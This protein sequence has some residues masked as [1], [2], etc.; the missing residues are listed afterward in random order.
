MNWEG[1]ITAMVTPLKN[2]GEEV[3]IDALKVYCDF[4]VE[5]NI[6]GVFVCGT[7]GEGPK[8]K[9][10]ERMKI[11]ETVVERLKG[12]IKTIIH[13]GTIITS[14][15]IKLSKHAWKIGADAVVVVLPYYY[16]YN[17]DLLYRYFMEIANVI[18]E[19]PL[20]IYNIPQCAINNLTPD[21]FKRLIEN[22]P[23]IVGI[24]N[25]N[26]DIHQDIEFIQ[27]ANG[28]CSLFIGDDGLIV[29]GLSMGA[30]GLVSGNASVFP[31]YFVDLYKTFKSGNLIAAREKQHFINKLR[32]VLAREH[33]IASFKKAL[34]FRGVNV[35]N[36]RKPDQD[37]SENE[38]NKLK[39]ALIK[40]GV[41]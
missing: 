27:I 5:K 4:L 14:D 1:V 18:P 35:G 39:Q 28:K 19:M 26:S 23:S 2:N 7:T 25:S 41:I 38:A 22:I 32:N 31:E 29:S 16:H 9:L 30:N 37:L 12:K 24:K 13:T 10:D 34:S 6:D 17:D 33:D 20:F 11:S 21:L 3:D 40:L 36:V 15:T 8:L